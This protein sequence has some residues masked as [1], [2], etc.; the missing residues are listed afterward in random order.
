[1]L[2]AGK[3]FAKFS[4]GGGYAR[5]LVTRA[6]A[7]RTAEMNQLLSLID[8]TG[9]TTWNNSLKLRREDSN[10]QYTYTNAA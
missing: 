3:G 1:M 9:A 7:R 5:T 8:M 10:S 6:R 4:G 2:H